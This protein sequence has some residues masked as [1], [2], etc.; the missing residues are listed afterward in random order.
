MTGAPDRSDGDDL[1]RV[2]ET[3]LAGEPEPPFYDTVSTAVDGGRRL[4]RRR[5]AVTVAGLLTASVIAV[6]SGWALT[7]YVSEPT[8]P[9]VPAHSPVSSPSTTRSGSPV[10][11]G[12]PGPSE[13][14]VPTVSPSGDRGPAVKGSSLR[15]G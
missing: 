6:V 5:R 3:I 15:P 9:T 7:H 11:S 14:P 2:F 1:R 4:R 13:S 12:D 8:R 10:P